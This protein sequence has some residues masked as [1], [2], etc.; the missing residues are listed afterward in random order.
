VPQGLEQLGEHH[1][2]QEALHGSYWH[3][4]FS[5]FLSSGSLD[6]GHNCDRA[7]LQHGSDFY[8]YQT[9]HSVL[10]I[11]LQEEYGK[12]NEATGTIKI[13]GGVQGKLADLSVRDSLMGTTVWRYKISTCPQGLTQLFSGSIKV[14]S[15]SSTDFVG[16]VAL[17]EEKG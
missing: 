14:F 17:L 2:Q 3:H 11:T 9:A 6:A 8:T 10:E 1:H 13:S 4:N 15:N 16:A 7:D 5:F 12:I